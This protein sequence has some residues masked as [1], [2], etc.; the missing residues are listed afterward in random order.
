MLKD[1]IQKLVAEE[2]K[3]N[4]GSVGIF[5][6][7]LTE[8][9]RDEATALFAKKEDKQGGRWER[10]GSFLEDVTNA[11]FDDIGNGE[12]TEAKKADHDAKLKAIF[13]QVCNKTNWKLPINAVIKAEDQRLATEAIIYFTGGGDIHVSQS[14]AQKKKGLIR[15]QAPGYYASVGA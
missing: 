5:L 1:E 8:A 14:G 13:E 4:P 10:F 6:G 12:A 15:I 2:I 3:R 9:C 11:F 7:A